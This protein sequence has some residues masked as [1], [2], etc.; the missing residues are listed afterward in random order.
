MRKLERGIVAAGLG[1][2]LRRW[3]LDN[4]ARTARSAITKG[5]LVARHNRRLPS[6]W[7]AVRAEIRG[8]ERVRLALLVREARRKRRRRR[9]IA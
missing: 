7:R 1:H 4:A 5:Q 6:R 8:T 2:P 3:R 9:R